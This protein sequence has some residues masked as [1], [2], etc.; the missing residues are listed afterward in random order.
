[1]FHEGEYIIYVNGDSYKIGQIK[2]IV[3][4]GAFVWYHEGSTASKTPF[5]VMH[6]LTNSYVIKQ[7]SLNSLD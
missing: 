2:R 5:D 4:D 3:A 1:M 6:K 7:T